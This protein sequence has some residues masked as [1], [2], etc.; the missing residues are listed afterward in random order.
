[1]KYFLVFTPDN[2]DREEANVSKCTTV[3]G[4]IEQLSDIYNWKSQ[5]NRVG[6]FKIG[7]KIDSIMI[8]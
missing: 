6:L 8:K 7:N 5:S 3:E 4:A 2:G 1:M